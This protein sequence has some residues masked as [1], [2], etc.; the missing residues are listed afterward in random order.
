MRF[1]RARRASR[2]LHDRRA[3]NRSGAP[4]RGWLPAASSPYLLTG[5]V[6]IGGSATLTIEAGVTVYG[7]KDD[8]S[9]SAPGPALVIDGSHLCSGL[10]FWNITC[11]LVKEL[12][13]SSRIT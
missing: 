5:Q 11:T 2:R 3:A 9:G 10:E 7:Y 12:D 8:G 1:A 6:F 13:R 4:A